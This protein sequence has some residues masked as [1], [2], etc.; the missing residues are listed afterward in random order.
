[1]QPID[2]I[3]MYYKL[4]KDTENRI[5]KVLQ[6]QS[7]FIV[8]VLKRPLLPISEKSESSE[9]IIEEEQEVNMMIN[10]FDL[11]L[12]LTIYYFFMLLG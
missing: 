8:K 5:E 10:L 4:T 2:P 12:L 7:D 6:S 9:I 11:Y 1:M 3:L